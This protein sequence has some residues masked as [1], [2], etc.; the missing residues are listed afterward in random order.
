MQVEKK[1]STL[2]L[3]QKYLPLLGI[4]LLVYILF[5]YD[6]QKILAGLLLINWYHLVAALLLF[7]VNI[8]FRIWRWFR[9]LKDTYPDIGFKEST[10]FYLSS[11]F[12]GTV[13]PG[14]VGELYKMRL[15]SRQGGTPGQAF[16]LGIVD[17]L[18]D[19]LFLLG[20]IVLFL[21][22]F[23]PRV[24]EQFGYAVAG[25]LLLAG[26]LA[27][28]I[29]GERLLIWLQGI[30]RFKLLEHL[31]ELTRAFKTFISKRVFFESLLYTG[32]S[33]FLYV[34]SGSLFAGAMQINISLFALAMAF[35]LAIIVALVP[36]T[37]QGVGTREL[38]L[39]QFGL[40]Y[41]F[42]EQLA[43]SLS[44]AMLGLMLTCSL[45]WGAL[46]VYLERKYTHDK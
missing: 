9:I 26:A 1:Q 13:T 46:G 3:I 30:W 20:F 28:Y 18:L 27:W 14:R 23:F 41:G 11:V 37:F 38:I 25:L 12:Y 24:G 31:L 21:G 22:A 5:Q 44:M 10:A 43:V 39:I 45:G 36:V 29:L 32:L 40:T 17:R 2:A 34:F 42:D 33:W 35:F 7:S 6:L 4:G 8:F 19:I 15:V 16:F